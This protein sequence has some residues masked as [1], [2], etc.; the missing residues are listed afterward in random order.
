MDERREEREVFSR[1][2][3]RVSNAGTLLGEGSEMEVMQDVQRLRR[4]HRGRRA[5]SPALWN[6]PNR[7]KRG[8][9]IDFPRSISCTVPFPAR[10]LASYGRKASRRRSG[11]GLAL[12]CPH[13]P[14]VD[15]NRHFRRF[16]PTAFQLVLVCR[17]EKPAA[18]PLRLQDCSAERGVDY[19]SSSVTSSGFFTVW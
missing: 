6:E 17:T 10:F 11:H 8:R 7:R 18:G 19:N 1:A 2:S 12:S 9:K 14:K 15:R 13:K 3:L 16:L 5:T 4:R